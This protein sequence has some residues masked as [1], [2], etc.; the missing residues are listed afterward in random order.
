M[1]D[2]AAAP[3]WMLDT[4]QTIKQADAFVI[5]TPEYNCALPPALT[6][7][8]D[9]FPPASY[10]HK[11]TLIL[12]AVHCRC[13]LS[14]KCSSVFC[15]TLFVFDAKTPKKPLEHVLEDNLGD[16]IADDIAPTRYRGRQCASDKARGR[17]CASTTS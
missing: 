7:M 14:L 12:N 9:Y 1:Q 11:V 2:Q 8:L 16:D 3:Q 6:N 10:R 4:H 13:F 15:R 17:Q 5:V